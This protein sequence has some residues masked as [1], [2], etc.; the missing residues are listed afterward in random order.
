MSLEPSL[1]AGV[2]AGGEAVPVVVVKSHIPE[3]TCLVCGLSHEREFIG[4]AG[5]G[6]EGPGRGIVEGGAVPAYEAKGA[7]LAQRGE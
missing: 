5:Q 3:R 6:D 2:L 7:P 1:S 4:T